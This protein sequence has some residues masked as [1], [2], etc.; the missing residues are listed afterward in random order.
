M[1]SSGQDIQ[2][3]I[4]I[5]EEPVEKQSE[6]GF[7]VGI[8]KTGSD[9]DAIG[10]EERDYTRNRQMHVQLVRCFQKL[11]LVADRRTS[12]CEPYADLVVALCPDADNLMDLT[13]G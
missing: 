11:Q 8:G 6:N 13:V 2:T 9:H 1:D 4:G 10:F 12:E 7:S 3:M 5:L